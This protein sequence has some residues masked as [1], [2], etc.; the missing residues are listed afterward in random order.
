M[1]RDKLGKSALPQALKLP[2][3]GGASTIKEH[4]KM[5]LLSEEL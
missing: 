5:V 3:H 1:G 2:E 4:K